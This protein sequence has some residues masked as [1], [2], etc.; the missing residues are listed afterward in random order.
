MLDERVGELGDA[1]DAGL[2]TAVLPARVLHRVGADAR[3]DS[4]RQPVVEAGTAARVRQADQAQAVVGGLV[5]PT[6]P[7][8]GVPGVAYG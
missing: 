2:V 5:E 3:G 6:G 4:G 1:V 7:G 8:L